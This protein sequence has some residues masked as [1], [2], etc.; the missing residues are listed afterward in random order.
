MFSIAFWVV[1]KQLEWFEG[2]KKGF[3][4][5]IYAQSLIP[6]VYKS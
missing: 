3:L 6:E 4:K 2:S 1:F 5:E